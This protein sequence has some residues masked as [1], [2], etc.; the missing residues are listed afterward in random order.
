MEQN[1]SSNGKDDMKNIRLN[2]KQS[3]KGLEYYDI[4]V[5]GDTLE[6]VKE[7]MNTTRSYAKKIC[8]PETGDEENAKD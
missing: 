3:A 1:E 2:I 6:E 5:R 4:T 8:G 7:L